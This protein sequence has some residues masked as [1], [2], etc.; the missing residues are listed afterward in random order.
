MEFANNRNV[1]EMKAGIE[2]R[3]KIVRVLASLFLRNYKV[4]VVCP[5][6]CHGPLSISKYL[7]DLMEGISSVGTLLEVAPPISKKD[8]R[9]VYFQVFL[10]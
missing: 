4:F 9:F 2:R 7:L 8:A 10:T 6:L 5:I 1:A 3:T